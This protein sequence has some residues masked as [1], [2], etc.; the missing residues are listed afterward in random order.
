MGNKGCYV[1]SKN[2]NLCKGLDKEKFLLF[3][4]TD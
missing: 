4:F 3:C 2:I 1:I